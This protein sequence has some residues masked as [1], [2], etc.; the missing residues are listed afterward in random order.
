MPGGDVSNA[1]FA[2]VLVVQLRPVLEPC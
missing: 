1:A 2:N